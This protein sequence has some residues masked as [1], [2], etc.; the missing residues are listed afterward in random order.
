[1]EQF[2]RLEVKIQFSSNIYIVVA[3]SPKHIHK[4]L[5]SLSSNP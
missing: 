3:Q 5:E 1:M 4:L 2:D